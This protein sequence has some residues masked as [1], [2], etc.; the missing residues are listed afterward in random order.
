MEFINSRAYEK[1][2]MEL[3]KNCIL[4]QKQGAESKSIKTY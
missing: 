4:S 3:T 2:D 1:R